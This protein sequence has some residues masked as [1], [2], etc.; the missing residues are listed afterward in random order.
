MKRLLLVD[1]EQYNAF[2]FALI[3]EE[4][5]FIVDTFTDPEKV[6][7][8]FKP[9]Y[10]DLVILDY[11]MKGLDGLE[12]CKRIKALDKSVKALLLNAGPEQLKLKMDEVTNHFSGIL[13][14]PVTGSKLLKEIG[15]ILDQTYDIPRDTQET[16]IET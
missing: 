6:L 12:L 2:V 5:D 3:L 13:K 4:L 11:R 14:K 15:A 1:D 9:N 16:T 8:V 10:Y 7:S